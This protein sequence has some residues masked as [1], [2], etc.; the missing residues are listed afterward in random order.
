M[1][2]RTT[3]IFYFMTPERILKTILDFW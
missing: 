1:I 2:A 3:R